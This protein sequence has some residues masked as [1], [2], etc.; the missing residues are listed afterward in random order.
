MDGKG[1]VSE[2]GR[3]EDKIPFETPGSSE[4]AR[5]KSVMTLVSGTDLPTSKFNDRHEGI[6]Y[7]IFDR[8]FEL[9]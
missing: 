3:I 7:L 2:P 4:W 8:C 5:L 9:Q 1:C 6:P